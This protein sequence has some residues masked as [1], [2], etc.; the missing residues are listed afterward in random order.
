MK[1]LY[2]AWDYTGAPRYV[3]MAFRNLRRRAAHVNSG[4][5][6]N[7]RL[8]SFVGEH[9]PLRVTIMPMEDWDDAE[10]R[11]AEARLILAFGRED[12]G[13]GPLFNGNDGEE[14]PF[15]YDPA[16]RSAAAIK[17]AATV[18]RRAAAFTAKA[19]LGKEG[20]RLAARA[21]AWTRKNG[22][23]PGQNP[24]LKGNRPR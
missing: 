4:T 9:G 11:R 20:A 6:H 24:F 8:N 23:H 22:R 18:R 5:S 15:A 10:V 19:K 12:K 17:A 3:G 21:A 16:I 13:T 14:G 1:G 7:V 2:V